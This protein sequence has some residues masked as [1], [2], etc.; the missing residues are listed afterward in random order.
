MV[1]V[2]EYLK[3]VHDFKSKADC[4]WA[5]LPPSDVN[6]IVSEKI[7]AI[8]RLR[9]TSDV[10]EVEKQW[11][12]AVSYE[13][14]QDEYTEVAGEL[15]ADTLRVAHMDQN[16]GQMVTKATMRRLRWP[17][18]RRRVRLSR[19]VPNGSTKQQTFTSKTGRNKCVV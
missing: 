16:Q 11:L 7:W 15:G 6:G 12:N 5:L 13:E 14:A 10:H 4:Q 2:I 1:K 8:A 17:S 3:G 9:A 19:M 18:W